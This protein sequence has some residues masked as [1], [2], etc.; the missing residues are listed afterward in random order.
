M[1]RIGRTA[2]AG[3]EGKAISLVDESSALNS[4]PSRSSSATRSPWSGQRTTC[5]WMRS[6]RPPK[7]AGA[8]PRRSASAWPSRGGPRRSGGKP[9]DAGRA[10]AERAHPVAERADL[11][12]APAGGID[13]HLRPIASRTGAPSRRPSPRGLGATSS[14]CLDRAFTSP[15]EPEIYTSS[16]VIVSPTALPSGCPP[17][18]CPPSAARSAGCDSKLSRATGWKTSARS[19]NPRAGAGCSPCRPT[20]APA[21]PGRRMSQAGATTAPRS[22]SGWPACARSGCSAST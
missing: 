14:T 13:P 19:S 12:L 10:E 6:S 11:G 18:S 15:I 1:H 16:F 9:G 17:S 2:R 7:S 8:S 3:A 4:R 5:F 20:A 21:S 22:P